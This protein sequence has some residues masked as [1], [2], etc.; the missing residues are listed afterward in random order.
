[1]IKVI[2]V[3]DEHIVRK[4]LIATVN[5][6]DFNM[7]VVGDASNGKKGW[8][9]FLEQSPDVVITDIVMPEQNG[10][11]LA[12]KIKEKHHGQKYYCSAATVILNM[13]KKD[14][15]SGLPAIF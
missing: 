9:L 2:V 15:I 8:E 1:M 3:D 5:W 12:R 11:E 13:R 4:G 10:I 6:Q 7:E 14:L